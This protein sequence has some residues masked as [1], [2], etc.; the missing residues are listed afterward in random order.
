[1]IYLESMETTYAPIEQG[2]AQPVPDPSYSLIPG[3][4]WLTEENVSFS[5]TDKL[6]GF[7]SLTGTG[8]TYSSLFAQ[9]SGVPYSFNSSENNVAAGL[10][11]IGDILAEQGY[12]QEFICGS[13]ASFAA[14][15]AFFERHGG[16]EIFDYNTAVEK[17]YIPEGYFVWWGFEDKY[18]YK[19]A[20][21]E[22][23]RL[24]AEGEPFNLTFLT[25]DTHH[26]GGYVC[27]LC[28]TSIE[29]QLASV[30][31]CADNQ[32]EDFVRW[33][34]KQDFYEDTTIVIVGD[35]PRMDMDLVGGIDYYDRT[36][37]NCYINAKP[38]YDA[39]RYTNRE[40]SALET[41]PTTL[42]ALGFKIEGNKLG[43]GVDMF[44]GESTLMEK[45][46]YDEL[47]KQLNGYSEFYDKKFN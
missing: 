39:K 1:M 46:G 34:M 32:I 5:N 8:W 45:I 40:F 21:D 24:A 27:D 6:G 15:G 41:F 30:V 47:N 35:H 38:C 28:D 31:D 9:S 3:L 19:I 12:N 22:A 17:G 26:Q 10:T 4:T 42:S 11:T 2:G 37:Y 16:Y 29:P 36:V 43:L 13:D 20:K 25:V 44:S 33:C 18:L 23:T 14:R 7:H